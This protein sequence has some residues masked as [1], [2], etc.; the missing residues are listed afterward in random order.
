MSLIVCLNVSM[1]VCV[2][3]CV[4]LFV[5]FYQYVRNRDKKKAREGSSARE[6]EREGK[7]PF[8]NF[9]IYCCFL[10]ENKKIIYRMLFNSI[11]EMKEERV[12]MSKMITNKL[13]TCICMYLG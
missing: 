8:L 2:C 7:N 3:V 12:I 9:G 6:R 13:S 4:C 5:C 1:R 11:M 10:H